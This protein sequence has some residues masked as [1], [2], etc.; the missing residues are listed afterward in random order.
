[1]NLAGRLPSS[2]ECLEVDGQ[3]LRGQLFL[4]NRPRKRASSDG[5]AV[6]RSACSRAAARRAQAR[7]RIERVA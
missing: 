2:A 7:S 3:L 1:L 6:R 4:R 5:C